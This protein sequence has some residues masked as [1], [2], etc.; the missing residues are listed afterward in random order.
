MDIN[1]DGRNFRDSFAMAPFPS[2]G[3]QILHV[4]TRAALE[5]AELNPI[6][7]WPGYHILFTLGAPRRLPPNPIPRPT[8][9]GVPLTT[10]S[11]AGMAITVASASRGATR[12]DPRHFRA[13]HGLGDLE[14]TSAALALEVWR[15]PVRP[16]QR[17]QRH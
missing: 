17:N 11:S 15:V 14:T 12:V 5:A 2:P 16:V 6:Q 3:V 4:T 10:I 1:R 13:L 8:F 9:D 7:A